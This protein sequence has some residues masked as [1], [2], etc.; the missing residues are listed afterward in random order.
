MY[1]KPLISLAFL[2]ALAAPVFSCMAA[3]TSAVPGTVQPAGVPAEVKAYFLHIDGRALPLRQA[4]VNGV[5]VLG[6]AVISLTLPLNISGYTKAGLNNLVLDYT[7]D[8]KSNL[9]VRVEKRTPGPK[10]EEIAKIEIPAGDSQGSAKTRAISFNLPADG[11]VAS[12]GDLNDADKAAIKEQFERYYKALA[13]AKADQ[14]RSLYRQSLSDERKL[15]PESARF[16]DNVIARE[17]A[18]LKNRDL[19]LSPINNDGLAFKVE[20]DIVKLYRQ[21]NK[22]LVESNEVDAQIDPLM[23]E[24]G[25]GKSKSGK[26]TAAISSSSQRTHKAKDIEVQADAFKPADKKPESKEPEPKEN[27][28]VEVAR[29]IPLEDDGKVFDGSAAPKPPAPDQPPV[30]TAVK[31]RLVRFN[32]YFKPSKPDSAGKRAWAISLPPNV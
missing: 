19:K 4:L 29:E 15:S 24:V 26:K 25:T 12:V 6:G 11:G 16:F 32:L 28:L 21:D 27:Q 10:T 30:R 2:V 31:E 7:S 23:I 5:N 17:V 9:T 13:S 14:V 22:P 3:E 1:R 18:I 8:P 20:G